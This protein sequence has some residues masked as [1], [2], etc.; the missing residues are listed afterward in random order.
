MVLPYNHH[1]RAYDSATARLH[2]IP[3]SYAKPAASAG[4]LGLRERSVQVAWT[5]TTAGSLRILL[6]SVGAGE[7]S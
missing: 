1:D 2:G 3:E 5:A 4:L 6:T 7:S